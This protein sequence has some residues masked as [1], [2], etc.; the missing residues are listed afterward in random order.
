V[1]SG[2]FLA[3]DDPS[4]SVRGGLNEPTPLVYNRV[5]KKEGVGGYS[6]I[7]GYKSLGSRP[8]PGSPN[9]RG[10]LAAMDIRNGKVIWKDPTKLSMTAAAL[11]TA[12]GLVVVGDAERYL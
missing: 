2:R 1:I 6:P 5:E 4:Y 12:G 11:T 10:G 8:Q 9:H 7:P 3:L